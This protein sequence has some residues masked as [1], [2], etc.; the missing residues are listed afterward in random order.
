MLASIIIPVLNE[1]N[2]ISKCVESI[3]SETKYIKEI[4][5]LIIDGGSKDKTIKVIENL[6][7]KYSFIKLLHNKKK[8]TPAALNI[9]IKHADGKYIIR[10][11][12]HAEYGKNYVDNC[13][14]A[15]ESAEES[16][17]NVGGTIETKPSKNT[18]FAK[19]I[20]ICLS[21]KF[22]VGNSSFRISKPKESR[23]V[24]TVP[25]GCF[26]KTIFKEI[27]SFNENE[28]RNED[29][30]FN[31]RIIRSGKKILLVP[32]ITSI[33]FSRPDI[34]SFV[35]QQFDNG[36]IV[37][38]KFRGGNAFHNLRH[39]TPFFFVTYLIIFL[40]LFSLL[41]KGILKFISFTPLI[42]YLLL[43]FFFSIY[44]AIKKNLLFFPS[45]F[46][47]YILLHVSY[48]VG[49]IYGVFKK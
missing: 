6:I 46:F 10:L 3:I 26:R 17:A 29:L 24:D 48:G 12:A 5:I 41:D 14:A 18:F 15:I 42:A 43:N 1:E 28:P 37:T 40:S 31:K 16:I 11:D 34:K 49:S 44:L 8:I 22:G 30:E 4:E 47:T 23:Y 9:G 39:F 35:L 7:S 36:K 45:L 21:S 2:F 38:N 20:S 25:F 33:Y 19:S 13:I 27:G 32:N